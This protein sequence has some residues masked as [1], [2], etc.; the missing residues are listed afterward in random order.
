MSDF[1]ENPF[2]GQENIFTSATQGRFFRPKDT[3]Y[4]ETSKRTIVIWLVVI[5]VLLLAV[6][7]FFVLQTNSFSLMLRNADL[8]PGT[9]TYIVKQGIT[10]GPIER[11]NRPYTVF[12]SETMPGGRPV[13]VYAEKNYWG[14]WYLEDMVIAE[15]E[16]DSVGIYWTNQAF[17]RRYDPN[18]DPVFETEVQRAYCGRNAVK[19]IEIKPEQLPPNTAVNVQ[20]AGNV[21]RIHTVSYVSGETTPSIDFEAILRENGCIQ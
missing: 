12:L 11:R 21:Y 7:L 13:L 14:F 16:G 5:A 15:D 4:K 2:G 6:I 8:Y 18:D 10:E 19:L 9:V 3:E 17:Y 20:Q 1:Q